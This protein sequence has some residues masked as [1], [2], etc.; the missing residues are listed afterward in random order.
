MITFNNKAA[1][2][3][4]L[5]ILVSLVDVHY[6]KWKKLNP[7][8]TKHKNA[9][10]KEDVQLI[11]WILDNYFPV[12]VLGVCLFC[13]YEEVIISLSSLMEYKLP[14]SSAQNAL[15]HAQGIFCFHIER[16]R[17][18]LPHCLPEI[19]DKPNMWSDCNNMT[20]RRSPTFLLHDD[21]KNSLY[22][23]LVWPFG[24]RDTA[25]KKAFA[26]GKDIYPKQRPVNLLANCLSIKDHHESDTKG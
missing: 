19:T 6:L 8:Q 2:E 7:K 5:D 13:F 16:N 3:H 1:K 24:G 4:Y 15:P 10:Q 26:G 25:G 14:C 20:G 9:M 11:H 12:K 22:S 18:Y 23:K 17:V 21:L